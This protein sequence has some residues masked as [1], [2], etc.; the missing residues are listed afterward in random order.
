MK[1]IQLED[2]EGFSNFVRLYI[3]KKLNFETSNQKV[4]QWMEQLTCF[5]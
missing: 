5:L 1:L 3:Q 4:Q 2:V